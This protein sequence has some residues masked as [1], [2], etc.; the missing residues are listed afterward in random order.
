MDL[1]NSYHPYAITTIIFWSLAYALTK[2]A[3]K[4][5]SSFSLGFL[6]YAIASIAMIIIIIALKIKLPK[7]KDLPLFILA[8]A[9]GFFMYMITFNKGAATVSSGTGSVI[10]ATAPVITALLASL[11]F[12]E[13]LKGFQWLGIT[14]QFAGVIILTLLNNIFSLNSG[15]VWLFGSALSL[16]IYNI[17]QR[18]LTKTYSSM[19]SSAFSILFGTLLLSIFSP[20]AIKE[21]ST[22][23]IGQIINIAVLGI[24][25]SAIAY[26]TWS[27]AFSKA[28][29]T[30]SVSNYMF[31]TPFVTSLFSFIIIRE[32]PDIATIV[33]G[34]VIL[35]GI[36]IFNFGE[37]LILRQKR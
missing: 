21:I 29:N 4:H 28:E 33:G 22:A 37:K 11:V 17:L 23:S 7:L 30:S 18:K 16:S 10:I 3:L 15:I 6:R 31:L 20:T 14:I 13:K 35:I 2:I 27:I 34:A 5:F 32:I 36:Y 19:Q 8:G 9:S 12:R 26:L 1:K 24:F 25:T